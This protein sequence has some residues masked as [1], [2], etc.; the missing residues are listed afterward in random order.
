MT[1][2]PAGEAAMRQPVHQIRYAW[3]ESSLVD[4]RGMGPVESTLV[5]DCS[6]CGMASCGTTC[7][8]PPPSPDS[9]SCPRWRGRADQEGDYNGPGDPD[10]LPVCC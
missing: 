10:R 3:S 4:N 7:G 1:L 2:L 5:G 6:L 9:P 8:R